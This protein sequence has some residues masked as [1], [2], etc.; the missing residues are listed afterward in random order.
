MSAAAA[1]Q[2]KH[3]QNGCALFERLHCD[4]SAAPRRRMDF[5]FSRPAKVPIPNWKSFLEERSQLIT[6]VSALL[7]K[8]VRTRSLRQRLTAWRVVRGNDDDEWGI[9]GLLYE[10]S[11]LQTIKVRH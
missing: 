3:Q 2:H 11:G 6:K 1:K 10:S 8:A 5:G 4:L 9:L 7:Y